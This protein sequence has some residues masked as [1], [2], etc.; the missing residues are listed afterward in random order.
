[1]CQSE[2]VP[3]G[4]V[5]T[6]CCVGLDVVSTVLAHRVCTMGKRVLILSCMVKQDD[7]V[8]KVVKCYILPTHSTC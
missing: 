7:G 1:M 2:I 8:H 3:G 6:F 4:N 5:D